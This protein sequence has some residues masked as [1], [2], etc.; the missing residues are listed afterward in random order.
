MNSFT[1]Q[2]K[3]ILW[4][5]YKIFRQK[6]TIFFSAF[7]IFFTFLIVC[8]LSVRKKEKIPYEKASSVP[9]MNTYE[10][11][12]MQNEVNHGYDNTIGSLA[13]V[14]PSNSTFGVSGDEFIS[15]VMNNPSLTL[16][17]ELKSMK[18]NSEKEL[19]DYVNDKYNKPVVAGIVFGDDYTDYT[20]RIK[21]DAIIDSKKEPINNFADNRR[22]EYVDLYPMISDDYKYIGFTD[23]DLYARTYIYLQNAVD[24]AIIQVKTNGKVLGYSVDIGKLSKPPVFYDSNNKE[25]NRKTF[26]GYGPYIALLFIGQFF[27][28]SNRLMEEKENKTGDGLIS[29]GA[30]PFLLWLTW[31]VIYIPLSVVILAAAVLFDPAQVLSQVNPILVVLLLFFYALS[32]YNMVVIISRIIKKG[33]TIIVVTCLFVAFIISINKVLFNLKFGEYGWITKIAG[34]VLSPIGPLFLIIFME[35]VLEQLDI[36]KRN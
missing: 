24:N 12:V 10:G 14:L 2:F 13:F 5:N 35:L 23:A 31:E 4:K 26:D 17:S 7:E 27:H 1:Q 28:I 19:T 34:A 25:E 33:K 36:L 29:I 30:Y 22:S 3:I 16:A 6:T 11:F 32:M 18:F 8:T 9:A 20:I 15:L 21:G